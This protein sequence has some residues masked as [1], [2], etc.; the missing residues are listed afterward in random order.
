MGITGKTIKDRRVVN[1]KL[2]DERIMSPPVEISDIEL[3]E[4]GE[5]IR[6]QRIRLGLTLEDLSKAS[7]ITDTTIMRA[8]AHGTRLR[9][10][11]AD[12][13]LRTLNMSLTIG[14]IKED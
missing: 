3:A 9:L 14:R 6:K 4:L 7:G 8:E 5:H 12:R 13:L 10:D 2:R 11:M 1:A